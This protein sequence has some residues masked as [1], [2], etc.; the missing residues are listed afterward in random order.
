MVEIVVLDDDI[1][2]I[3]A[4]KDI[5]RRHFGHVDEEYE[6]RCHTDTEEFLN[7]MK[8][9]ECDII[10]LDMELPGTSGLEVGSKVKLCQPDAVLI[11]ITNYV[12]YAVAAYE[13]NAFRYIP[14]IMMEEKL[15][16]AYTVLTNEM[17]LK[18]KRYFIV[19]NGSNLEKIPEDHILYIIKE[20]KYIRIVHK[21]GESK[22]RMTMNE[23][24][25]QLNPA[26]FVKIY[27]SY[28]ASLKHIMS[29]K[30]H[31]VKMRDG[32]FLPVSQPQLRNVKNRV[33]EYWSIKR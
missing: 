27:R 33:K 32:A 26:N 5:S 20:K 29:L 2:C 22:V 19:M 28:V 10:L 3:E 24:Y 9:R 21:G 7:E 8:E 14:K 11:F 15:P 13:V 6:L 23:A 17:K 12:E 25:E 1:C 30:D 18:E 16:E 4:I 31:Q